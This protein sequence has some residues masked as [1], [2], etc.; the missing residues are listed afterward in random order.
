MGEQGE[1]MS[2]KRIMS[3]NAD[4][5]GETLGTL[6]IGTMIS[7]RPLPRYE[8]TCEKCGAQSFAGQREI[9]QGTATC[10]NSACGKEGIYEELSMTPARYA[11]QLKAREQ[12][13]IDAIA[14]Q[15]HEKANAIARLQQQQIANGV[16]DE[17][18]LRRIDAEC[19]EISMTQSQADSYNREQYRLF[20]ANTPGWFYC[21]GNLQVIQDYLSRNGSSG[22]VSEKMLTAAFRRLDS[23]GLLEHRPAPE[24]TRQSQSQTTVTERAPAQ[25]KRRESEEGYDLRT[26]ER[27]KYTPY[28]IDRMSADEFK[29]IFR[30]YGERAPR[31]PT[32][33]AF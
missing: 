26:G 10:R 18:N 29:R 32:H 2:E 25:P 30:L 21:E 13:K 8:T 4:L 17:W 24:P 12:E 3:G 11:R 5:S 27:R 33:A 20:A 7:R 23:F 6:R 15:V 1:F 16:D 14:Q 28:E 9:V 31:F 19:C 22:I